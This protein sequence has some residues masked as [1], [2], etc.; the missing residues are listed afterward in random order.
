MN[1]GKK[2]PV[3]GN[4][5]LK[6]DGMMLNEAIDWKAYLKAGRTILGPELDLDAAPQE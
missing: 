4:I 2:P 1:G 6:H 3:K 5:F